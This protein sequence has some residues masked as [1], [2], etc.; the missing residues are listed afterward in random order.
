MPHVLD[1]LYVSLNLLDDPSLPL[2]LLSRA[3]TLVDLLC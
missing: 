2:H 3:T 1:S